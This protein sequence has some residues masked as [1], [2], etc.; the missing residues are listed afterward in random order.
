MGQIV[1][2]LGEL[3]QIGR[4]RG[5]LLEWDPKVRYARGFTEPATR[6][7]FDE[8]A[9][10]WSEVMEGTMPEDMFATLV[11]SRAKPE[12]DSSHEVATLS[13]CRAMEH[14]LTPWFDDQAKLNYDALYRLT[15]LPAAVSMRVGV[16]PFDP[17]AAVPAPDEPRRRSAKQSPQSGSKPR[18]RAVKK[19]SRARG[20]TQ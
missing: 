15:A 5:W 4:W 12:L 9:P 11:Q 20:R 17:T 18:A 10:D 6:N 13:L 14:I 16:D 7:V 1:T 19:G 3:L 8:D 2:L